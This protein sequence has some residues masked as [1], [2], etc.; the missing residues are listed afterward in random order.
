MTVVEQIALKYVTHRAVFV[1]GG[2]HHIRRIST[3][4]IRVEALRVTEDLLC[5]NGHALLS[6]VAQ[7]RLGLLFWLVLS[8]DVERLSLLLV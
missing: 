6:R 1:H 7:V 8:V 4:R 3:E 5:V 2:N